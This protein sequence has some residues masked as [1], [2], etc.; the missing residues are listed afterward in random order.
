[1][2]TR[3]SASTAASAPVSQ[4]APRA[5]NLALSLAGAGAV[6]GVVI[7]L[8]RVHETRPLAGTGSIGEAAAYAAM[9]C[10][11]AGFLAGASLLTVRQQ[12]WLRSLRLVRRLGNLL[13]LAAL[14]AV[15]AFL[16]T[17]VV[18]E[19]FAGAFPGVALDRWAGTF[20]VAASCAIAAYVA[21]DSAA[22]LTTRS[23]SGLLAAFLVAA[24]SRAP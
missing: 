4:D 15:F 14:H 24:S 23:L 11:G 22:H 19:V 1:M 10:A 6:I 17:S 20:W 18:F 8:V 21:V 3:A 7:G 2:S 5:E 16:L 12:P 13:G 9:A